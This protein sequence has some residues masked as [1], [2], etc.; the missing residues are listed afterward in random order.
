[1]TGVQ[2]CALPISRN[3]KTGDIAQKKY[4]IRDSKERGIQTNSGLIN[5][6]SVYPTNLLRRSLGVRGSETALEQ[7]SVGIRPLYTFATPVLHGT[8]VLRL[9]TGRTDQTEGMKNSAN[10][11]GGT[12]GLLGGGI[13][14]VKKATANGLSKL[15]V[16]LPSDLNPTNY[17]NNLQIITN[18]SETPVVLSDI[19][20]N[21]EGGVIGKALA[22][23]GTPEQIVKNAA[24]AAVSAIKQKV[25]GTIFGERSTTG[26]AKPKSSISD[27]LTT[28]NYGSSND[29]TSIINV[30]VAPNA[31]DYINAA[32]RRYS[33]TFNLTTTDS[34]ELSFVD[35]LD[36]MQSGF[37][38]LAEKTPNVILPE[39]QSRTAGAGQSKSYS[40]LTKLNKKGQTDKINEQS[41]EARRGMRNGSDI[42]NQSGV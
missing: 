28:I 33:K 19:R 40:K 13:Q 41:L 42:I 34:S 4:D 5:N 26:F 23:G 37:I 24:G 35:G 10:G 6:T 15:G 7:E 21:G 12:E 27:A 17:V 9:E 29:A 8:D 11:G 31:N 16:K 38:G 1:V 36:E 30:S 32:G 39:L 18:K 14:S 25:R 20:S 22:Q 3:D 2:T